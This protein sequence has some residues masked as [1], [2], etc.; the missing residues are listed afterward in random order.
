MYKRKRNEDDYPDP[1]CGTIRPG[2]GAFSVYPTRSADCFIILSCQRQN[3]S[4]G[5]DHRINEFVTWNA[6]QNQYWPAEYFIDA[7][8]T[9]RRTHF[10]EGCYDES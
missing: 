3:A 4:F 2:R 10:S 6:Y 1:I 8:G 9:L 5:C 7:K